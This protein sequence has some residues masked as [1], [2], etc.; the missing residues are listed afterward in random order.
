MADVLS[1]TTFSC[2]HIDFSINKPYFQNYVQD[3][4]SPDDEERQVVVFH[5]VFAVLCSSHLAV[6]HSR[7]SSVL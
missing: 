1:S 2:K 3:Q 7:H 5:F 6:V 4:F